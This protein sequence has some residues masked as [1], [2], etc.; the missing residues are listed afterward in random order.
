MI[1]TLRVIRLALTLL[2]GVSFAACGGD[3]TS[4][5]GSDNG[6]TTPP[7]PPAPALPAVN[8]ADNNFSPSSLTVSVGERVTWTWVGMN[9]HNVT[10]DDG[11]GNSVT[12]TSGTHS[13]RFNAAGAFPYHCTIHGA[14]VMSG[15]VAVQ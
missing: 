11:T 4:G 8:I 7:P 14:S 12:R 15:T 13:R 2:L 6:T 10:F 3:D 5:P 9:S 1:S